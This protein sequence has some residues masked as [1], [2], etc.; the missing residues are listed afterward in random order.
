MF[1][2]RTNYN[3]KLLLLNLNLK[4]PNKNQKKGGI[5]TK[6]EDWIIFI[7]VEKKYEGNHF[8][9]AIKI[10]SIGYNFHNKTK[11]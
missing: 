10:R 11:I 9:Y 6:D 3:S 2:A 1:Y 5:N 4:E 8:K 7:E